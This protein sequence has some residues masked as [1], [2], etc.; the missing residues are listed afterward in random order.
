MDKFSI[1]GA[2]W[3]K[4][5][6]II[7][8]LFVCAPALLAQE[9]TLAAAA[10]ELWDFGVWTPIIRS[11]VY[12]GMFLVGHAMLEGTFQAADRLMVPGGRDEEQL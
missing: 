4:C 7:L 2:R 11:V 8:M 9:G 12:E 6:A 5:A 10:S 3:L 1:S